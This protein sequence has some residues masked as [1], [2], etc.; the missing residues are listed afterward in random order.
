VSDK[1]VVTQVQLVHCLNETCFLLDILPKLRRGYFALEE[2]KGVAYEAYSH[3][4]LSHVVLLVASYLRFL[5]LI[6]QIANNNRPAKASE[7][8]LSKSLTF[9]DCI[10]WCVLCPSISYAHE[11]SA[12][13]EERLIRSDTETAISVS[14]LFDFFSERLCVSDNSI[15][16][17]QIL[18]ILSVFALQGDGVLMEKLVELSWVSLHTIYVHTGADVDYS[19]L[20][21]ALSESA[22][23]FGL[24]ATSRDLQSLKRVVDRIV[25][26]I[27]CNSKGVQHLRQGMLRHLGLV[28]AAPAGLSRQRNQLANMI[29]ELAY[30]LESLNSSIGST[31]G[32]EKKESETR[33]CERLTDLVLPAKIQRTLSQDFTNMQQQEEQ[34]RQQLQHQQLAQHENE[35]QHAYSQ[36]TQSHSHLYPGQHS[37]EPQQASGRGASI[38]SQV[39]M[40]ELRPLLK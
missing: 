20:P 22:R 38:N 26:K 32:E 1:S 33:C 4:S 15:V 28:T 5:V 3:V 24:K 27:Y 36:H 13:D 35:Q 34:M 23:R 37:T 14:R 6:L 21:F 40:E 39:A 9:E 31:H 12:N 30:L 29:A 8:M 10:K 19:S 25:N 11:M 7:R 17:D 16:A 2:R 18:E